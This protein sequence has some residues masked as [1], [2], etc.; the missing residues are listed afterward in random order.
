MPNQRTTSAHG[1]SD[2]SMASRPSEDAERIGSVSN[3]A[4]EKNCCSAFCRNVSYSAPTASAGGSEDIVAT[5]DSASD[6]PR[7]PAGFLRRPGHYPRRV[8]RPRQRLSQLRPYI[9]RGRARRQGLRRPAPPR[10]PRQGRHGPVLVREPAGMDRG[11]VGL[12]AAGR[13][14]GADRLPRVGRL[15]PARAQH[16][17]GPRAPHRPRGAVRAGRRGRRPRRLAARGARLARHA[18]R[19]PMPP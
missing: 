9:R 7:N 5:Y 16:R 17:E 13:G 18:A 1:S 12:P 14:G 8:P 19:C 2:G 11:S 4:R 3:V 15:P 10:R 6:A